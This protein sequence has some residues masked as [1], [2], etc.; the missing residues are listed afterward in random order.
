MAITLQKT[1]CIKLFKAEREDNF[2]SDHIQL[3]LANIVL[4]N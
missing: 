2:F 4:F 1:A 3:S